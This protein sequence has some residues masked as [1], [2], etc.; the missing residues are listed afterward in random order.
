MRDSVASVELLTKIDMNVMNEV[1][2]TIARRLTAVGSRSEGYKAFLAGDD[3]CEYTLYRK[4]MLSID[5]PFFVPYDNR[6]V[7]VKGWVEQS[8]EHT[9]ICVD[10]LGLDEGAEQAIQTE[11]Q[12]RRLP[13]KLKK[14]IK[15]TNKE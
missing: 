12:P 15:R 1:R 11:L 2:G 4:D 8:R 7:V 6:R 14:Q 3:G 5:D 13:R 9:S 10:S